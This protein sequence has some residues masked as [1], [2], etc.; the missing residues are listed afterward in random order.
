MKYDKAHKAVEPTWKVGDKVLLQE[1]TVKPGSS[2]IITKQRFV[3]PYVIKDIVVGRSDVGQA[4]RLIDEVTGK[5]L[6][7]LASNDRLK[8]YNVNRDEF[9]ARLPSLQTGP[10]ALTQRLHTS[11]TVV[12]QRQA[13][14]EEPRPVEIMSK[15]RVAGK[16]QYRVK[17]RR[18]GVQL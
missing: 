4:Y 12:G 2:K 5:E 3:G 6:R 11:Q 1:T 17:Y 18:Q 16:N 10:G 14:P 15:R 13:G 7:H 9:N 8:R